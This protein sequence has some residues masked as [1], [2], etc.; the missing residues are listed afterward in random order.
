MEFD[1]GKTDSLRV[2]LRIGIEAPEMEA[3]SP[4][5]GIPACHWSPT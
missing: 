5:G 3:E 4:F 1:R 2:Y